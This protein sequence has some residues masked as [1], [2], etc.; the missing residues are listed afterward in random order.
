MRSL[1]TGANGF[2]G[3]HLLKALRARGDEVRA[4]VRKDA[5][6][7]RISD[8]L[9]FIVQGD[10]RDAASLRTAL[11]GVVRVFHCAAKVS[12]WGFE[13][14]FHDANVLGTDNLL[15]AARAA[16]VTRFIHVSST[17]VYGYPGYPADESASY[18]YRGFP[19]V[20]T[21]IDAEKLVWASYRERG[22]PVTVLRPASIYGADSITLVRDIVD[23]LRKGEMVHLGLRPTP[24]GL[25]H[26]DNLVQA[27][28]LAADAKAAVGQAYNVTDGSG[29]SWREY[30]DG[31]ADACGFK[32]AKIVLPR[33]IAYPLA[34]CM[35]AVARS[36]GQ[37]KRPLLTRMAVEIFTT[38]Q[39][40]SIEKIKRELGYAPRASFKEFLK[41][42]GK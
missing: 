42:M 10:L 40:F 24:A 5:D 36:A 29:I 37:K 41:V 25:C 33:V 17:D 14:E 19:Y 32:R 2:V 28:L 35:E 27:M 22:F 38:N 6:T 1:V 26:V 34:A 20:D 23:L 31:L 12:D 3:S 11:R 13:K 39:E 30:V 18:R 8:A 21:K 9:D 16:G 15:A 4:L 7:S